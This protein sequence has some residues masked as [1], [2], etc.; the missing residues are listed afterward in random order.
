MGPLSYVRS[1]VDRNVVMRRIPACTHCGVLKHVLTNHAKQDELQMSVTSILLRMARRYAAIMK[2]TYY[3]G[4]QIL[5]KCRNHFQI[6]GAGRAVWSKFH[7]RG[8]TSLE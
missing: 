7:V 8:P 3:R 1:V 5:L 6:L 4:P 2:I